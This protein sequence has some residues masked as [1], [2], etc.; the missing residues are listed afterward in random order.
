MNIF[1]IFV[2][3][4]LKLD[5]RGAKY[6][7]G[8][9]IRNFQRPENLSFPQVYYTF[10]AKDCDS[11]EIVN[12]IVQDLPEDRADEAV[13]LM[14]KHFLPDETLCT[15]NGLLQ[16]PE[17]VEEFKFFWHEMTKL[18]FSLVCFREGHEDIVAVNFII[19]DSKDDP[20][21]DVQFASQSCGEVIKVMEKESPNPDVYE[22][23]GVKN[24]MTAMG[25]CVN[26]AYRRRGIATEM[27]KARAPFLKKLNLKVTSTAF[28]GIGSQKAA[29][30]AGYKDIH[31]RSY[32]EI[33]KEFTAFDFTKCAT[34]EFKYMALEI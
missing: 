29:A 20:K 14:V 3:L 10:K 18:K 21:E 31:V 4:F 28:T 34:K 15:A 9:M 6:L 16:H 7:R 2:S 8:A 11:D 33:G 17:A 27:L 25:L 12:Y 5:R 23:F 26:T 13:E 22:R 30:L 1:I 19:I 32:D 24:Y